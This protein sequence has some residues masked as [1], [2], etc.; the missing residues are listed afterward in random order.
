[1]TGHFLDIAGMRLHDLEFPG[2]PPTLVCLP[3]LSATAPIFEDL[4]VTG[5]GGAYRTIALDLRGRGLSDAPPAGMDPADPA[6]NYRMADH[7][8]DVLDLLDR[9]EI[10]RA[11]L[12]GHSFGGMLAFFLGA[13]HPERF[14]RLVVLDAAISVASPE[15]REVLAPMLARLGAVVPSWDAYLAAVKNLPYLQGRWNDSLERYFRSYVNIAAD[16]SVRQRVD[17]PAIRAAVEGILAED[18]PS[19]VRTIRQPCLLINATEP[20]GPAGSP[21]FLTEAGARATVALMPDCR[22]RAVGGNHITM[23]F[24]D[25]AGD[26]AAAI[27]EFLGEDPA[28]VTVD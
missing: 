13:H 10:G 11:V 27:R 14:P 17:R 19:L 6:A 2:G 24:G 5:L 22:Y 3:G 8:G 9:R 21:P 28:P 18:W 12:V 20:Y 23:V 1:M 4:I 15:T 26:V 7:A 16:G 25:H